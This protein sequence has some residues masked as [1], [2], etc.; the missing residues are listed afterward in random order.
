MPQ[1]MKTLKIGDDAIL[2]LPE[3]SLQGKSK[4]EV[5]SK[6]RQLEP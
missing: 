2:N 1:G 6:V 3:F 5:R 4:R